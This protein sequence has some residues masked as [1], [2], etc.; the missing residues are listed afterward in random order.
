[1][2]AKHCELIFCPLTIQKFD[3]YEVETATI[4]VVE[5]PFEAIF[6]FLINR[7]CNFFQGDKKTIE[8]VECNLS[9]FLLLTRTR[10]DFVEVEKAMFY[11][12]ARYG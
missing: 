10:F 1:V 6:C 9:H 4:P 5:W 8:A 3:F 12:V 11:V 7:K 2:F